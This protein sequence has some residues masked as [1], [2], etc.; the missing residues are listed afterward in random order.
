[1]RDILLVTVDSLRY[2]HLGCYGY[3]RETTPFL[4]RFA[5]GANRFTNAFANACMTRLSFPTI[6]ASSYPS[7]YG[8][9]EH[10]SDQRALLAEALS[11][12]GYV[13]G[14]FHSNLYLSADFGYDRGFDEFYDSK[15][16]P[17]VGVRVKEAVKTCLNENGWIHG[18]LALALDKLERQAGVSVGTPYASAEEI[19][20]KAI[21]WVVT[22]CDA[23]APRFLWTHYM[24][25]HH[26]YIP[27]A[28]HQR[29]F[30]DDPIDDRRAVKLRRKMMESPE[31]VTE[32]ELSCLIDLYDAEIRYTDGEIE[33]L[34]ETVTEA[35]GEDTVIVIT[36]DHGDEFCEHGGF[37]HT[38]TFYDEVVQV[39]LLID[40]GSGRATFDELVALIDI[41]PTAV[42][43][44]TVPCPENF[45]GDSLKPLIH[46][47]DWSREHVIGEN[48]DDDE[49][50]KIMYRNDR[51]KYI[52]GLESIELY[53]LKADPDELTN[54]ADKRPDVSDRINK[55]V[56]SHR[57]LV[58]D[59]A[60]ERSQVAMDDATK[61]RLRDLGYVE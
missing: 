27:P 45:H 51:W 57:T 59:H 8:G 26:P 15:T 9:P 12:G 7:M 38:A 42:D 53:D 60:G 1:M 40:D 3:N 35:W 22:C 25:P 17:G 46:G 19:T 54:V 29:T 30:R 34:V 24:D 48:L 23:D 61:R 31:A 18:A 16:D 41:P 44:A 37:S 32:R 5:A 13:T 50:T 28:Q 4:D 43:Y 47:G 55:L 11:K 33:R 2:D 52:E 56:E 6:L 58:T 10:M 49:L 14:G 36:A 20:N 21:S 39:P